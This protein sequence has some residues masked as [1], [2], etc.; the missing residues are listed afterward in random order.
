VLDHATRRP[1]PEVLVGGSPLR[2]VRLQAAGAAVVDRWVEGEPVGAGTGARTLARRLLDAG[3][4]HPRPTPG[5][6]PGEAAVTVVIP[7]RDCPVGLAATLRA[8]GGA[9]PVIVVD[10]GS[11][12]PPGADQGVIIRHTSPRG[13]A[14][15]RNTG[16][17]A[18]Q[19]DYVAFV[20]A[21]CQPLAGWLDL[22]LPHFADAA[23]GA[24]APRVRSSEGPPGLSEYERLRSPL[25]LGPHEAPVQPGSVVAYVP[26]AALVV[27]RQALQDI[28]GFDEALRF[29]E[30]VDLVWRL[31]R[32]GWRVR[33]EPAARA[34]H[35]SRPHLMAWLQQRYQ[36]GRSSAPLGLRHGKAVTHM[37]ISPYSAATWV[38]ALG[39]HPL[40]AVGLVAATTAALIRRAGGDRA[41]GRELARRALRSHLGAGAALA[42][43]VRRAW[44]PPVAL[45]A[46]PGPV[47]AA[48]TIPPLVEWF[49]G[50]AGG[51]GPVRWLLARCGDDLAYQAGVWTGVIESRSAAV[52]LPNWWSAAAAPA[53]TPP[54]GR[55]AGPAPSTRG[56]PPG[57]R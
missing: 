28:G 4:V 31:A 43:A 25:D 26:T 1:R 57:S 24:V 52:L 19:T 39:G 35:P 8:L 30:D 27:R 16:W 18:A 21:D 6:G 13:P 56:R 3:M 34:V 55:R 41:T 22:L 11:I 2:V 32:R 15:A 23:V 36:Y 46:G 40:A 44:L 47:A 29:G 54:G 12:S 49:G 5:A 7:V 38:L 42:T 48:L 14:A 9:N 10:D 17:Q 53:G 45:W 51:L 20:D 33:Y 50:R 37:T